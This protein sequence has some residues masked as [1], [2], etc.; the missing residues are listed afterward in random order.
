MKSLVIVLSIVLLGISGSLYAKKTVKVK[1]SQDA[2]VQGGETANEAM[3]AT[4]EGRMRVMKSNGNDKYS[5]TSYLQFDLKK[6]EDFDSVDLNICVRV[7]P[8]KDDAS[9]KFTLNIYSCSDN[10]WNENSLTF[11]NKPDK[12]ELLVSKV[13]EVSD[14][15][16]WTKISL[17]V[18]KVKELINN[19][20]KG[21]VSLVLSN[22][23]FNR[24]SIEII[25]K[26]RT[27]SNGMPAKREAYLELQ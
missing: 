11:E 17:P 14:D 2:F 27:W 18:E 20:K 26:E 24:T 8:C 25:T 5:R 23:D 3:G 4:T 10:K 21:K 1:V 22:D 15:N 19:S 13:L 7:Y 16:V 12:N 6:V 9:A